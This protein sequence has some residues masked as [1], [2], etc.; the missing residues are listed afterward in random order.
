MTTITIL[1][2]LLVFAMVATR[3][4]EERRWREGRLSDRTAAWLILGRLPVLLG[5]F[6]L[7]EGLPLPATAAAV[8]VGLV[9]GV[10]LHRWTV[11]RLRRARDRARDRAR[12]GR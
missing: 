5:G 7:I 4:F 3:P 10:L 12:T 8:L 1:L 6:C 2:A 11:G 9:P